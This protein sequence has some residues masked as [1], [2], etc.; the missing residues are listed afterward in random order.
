MRDGHPVRT[1]T[2]LGP[3]TLHVPL[4][5]WTNSLWRAEHPELWTALKTKTQMNTHHLNLGPTLMHLAGY[6]YAGMPQ[7][8]NL[9]APEFTAWKTLPI[10]SP[11][12]PEPV[13]IAP[14]P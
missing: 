1:N 3:N 2:P 13:Q 6:E 14:L 12:S 7:H 11:A 10:A 9:L 8:R 4:I 5:V